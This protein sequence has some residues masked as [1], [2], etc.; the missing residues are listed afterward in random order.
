MV[1]SRIFY[2]TAS[3][4]PQESTISIDGELD[5][6]EGIDQVLQASG[7]TANANIDL[8]MTAAITDSVY[9]SMLTVTEEPLFV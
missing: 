4:L 1:K 9:L 3:K 2:S 6:W 8:V 5:D 7:T